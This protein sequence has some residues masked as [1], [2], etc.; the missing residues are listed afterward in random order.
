[1]GGKL[2]Q[3]RF[4][5]RPCTRLPPRCYD[6]LTPIAKQTV[7]AANS[8]L[9]SRYRQGPVTVPTMGTWRF[10]IPFSMDVAIYGGAYLG[11]SPYRAHSSAA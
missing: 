9:T 2:F 4:A 5:H 8:P 11:L 7:W 3:F 1:M 6:D 10:D